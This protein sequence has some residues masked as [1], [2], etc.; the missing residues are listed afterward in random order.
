MIEA[1]ILLDLVGALVLGTLLVARERNAERWRRDLARYELRFPRGLEPAKVA[2]FF[3]GLSGLAGSRWERAIRPQGLVFELSADV[4]GIR[5]WVFMPADD[6]GFVLATL[7]AALPG[8]TAMP[9]E[10]DEPVRPTAAAGLGLSNLHR[11]LA[12]ERSAD[13]STAIL[14]AV[15]PLGAGERVVVQWTISPAGPV[16]PVQAVSASHTGRPLLARL[17]ELAIGGGV[18]LEGDD[19]K[20]ARAKQTSALF[21]ATGRVGVVAAEAGRARRLLGQVLGAHHAANAP[22][23]HLFRRRLLDPLVGEALAGRQLP[24][25]HHSC[26]LNAA[27]LGALAAFPVGKTSL[28]G[29]RL[30]GCRQLAP[31]SDIPAGGRVLGTATFPGTW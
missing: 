31:A 24:I 29:L 23:V 19:L 8:V 3:N 20:L 25:A 22:G 5:H 11:P 2:A 14:A 10:D 30:A 6:V 13:I 18:G 26:I 9:V 16:A 4:D 15:Q 17:V 12:V 1:F 21:A 28:P 27:E 7:R